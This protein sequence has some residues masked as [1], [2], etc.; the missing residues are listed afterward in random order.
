MVRDSRRDA[1][2]VVLPASDFIDMQALARD[3]V[4]DR[5]EA[6]PASGLFERLLPAGMLTWAITVWALLFYFLMHL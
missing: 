4:R 3:G 5:A 6:R 2:I 1:W